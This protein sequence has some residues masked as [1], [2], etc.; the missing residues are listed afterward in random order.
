MILTQLLAATTLCSTAFFGQEPS[1]AN[2]TPKPSDLM[3]KMFAKYASAATLTGTVELTVQAGSDKTE[4]TTQIQYERP[5]SIYLRQAKNVRGSEIYLLTS[6]GVVFTYNAPEN[7]LAGVRSGERLM[8]SVFANNKA[9]TIGEIYAAGSAM[10]RDR[11]APLDI[12]IGRNQDL[13]FLTRQWATL[14]YRGKVDY[15]GKAVHY[16]SGQYREYGDAPVSGVFEML[17]SEEHDLLRYI[18]RMNI[19]T[20]EGGLQVAEVVS[21]WSSRFVVNGPVDRSLF[22]PVR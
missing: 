14:T 19:G 1:P 12:A 20:T 11:S 15:E 8:E 4:Y 9:Q 13:R 5:S 2:V 17:I 10:L 6:N 7:V 18:T 16:I 3:A 21:T 22:K